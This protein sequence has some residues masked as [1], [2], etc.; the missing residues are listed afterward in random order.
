[1]KKISNEAGTLVALLQENARRQPDATAYF[2]LTEGEEPDHI[3][4][5]H[6]L[7]ERARAIAA[8]LQAKSAAM[9][10]TETPSFN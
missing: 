3:I 1:M 2:F 9:Q 8:Q 4:T 10:K 7:D 6:Q 5:Y